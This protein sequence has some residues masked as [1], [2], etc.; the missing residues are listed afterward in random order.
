[1]PKAFESFPNTFGVSLEAG[2]TWEAIPPPPAEQSARNWQPE[3]LLW[4]DG[5]KS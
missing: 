5:L 4:F 2:S 3:T 1:M